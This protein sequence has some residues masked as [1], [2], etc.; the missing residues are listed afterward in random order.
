M[1]PINLFHKAFSFPYQFPLLY[2]FRHM[3]VFSQLMVVF[4]CFSLLAP[5]AREHYSKLFDSIVV[6]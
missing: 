6:D 2:N 3:F 5:E 4:K 1:I